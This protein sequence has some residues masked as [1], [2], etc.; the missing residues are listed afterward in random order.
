M[1]TLSFDSK[2][3]ERI[4]QQLD[5]YLSNELL[6]ETA[7]EVVRHLESCE[8]C[9]RDLE[10]RMRVRDVLQRAVAN[11]PMPE[12]MRANIL[13]TLR[14]SQRRSLTRVAVKRWALGFAAAA[15]VL[16]GVFAA[17][18][19]NL[20][21]GEQLIASIL[22]L[23]VSDHVI[24]AIQGHNYP[25]VAN[26]PDEIRE[27]L[28]ARYAPLL[29]VVQQ[30]LPGFELLEGHICSI[31][32]SD[33]KYVHFI[34]R[35]HGTILSV[36]L[37]E[38]NGAALPRDKLLLSADSSGLGIYQD[39]LSGME[40]AGFE[41]GQYFAFVVSDLNQKELLQLARGLA[42]ALN[43]T[44]HTTARLLPPNATTKWAKL[45]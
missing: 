22:K 41:S 2:R 42:P 37:T 34:T 10:S 29:Q 28:G 12:S 13:R 27:K 17:E 25:E 44:L 24:C 8:A 23:G 4:R 35:G 26:P 14:D 38:R 15:V 33:R 9:S 39:H 6:V 19:L 31:P 45:G 16:F 32:G 21:H 11:R 18:W 43:E 5:S 3:C 30:R 40:I 7:S 1:N 36:I 20:R